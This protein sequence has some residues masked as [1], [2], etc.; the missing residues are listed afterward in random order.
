MAKKKR[1][2]KELKLGQTSNFIQLNE[3][4]RKI[5]PFTDLKL[6]KY[7]S[8]VVEWTSNKQK[9]MVKQLIATATCLLM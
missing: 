6:F 1:N 5:L 2:T 8:K 9:A 7:Y 3:R 4:F